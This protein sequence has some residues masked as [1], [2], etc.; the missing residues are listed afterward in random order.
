[1]QDQPKK[2][3]VQCISENI[4]PLFSFK[5]FMVS[6]FKCLSH[7]E[8]IF[9]YGMRVCSNLT[10]LQTAVQLSEYHLLKRWSFPHC[11]SLPPLSRLIFFN[12]NVFILIGG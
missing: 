9:V 2:T 12:L 3:Q 1:M 5:S 10:D 11:I 8:F 6:L 4:L 7:L